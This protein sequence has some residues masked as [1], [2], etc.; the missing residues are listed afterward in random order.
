MKS[1]KHQEKIF[2]V[3]Y[4]PNQKRLSAKPLP[5]NYPL[6]VVVYRKNFPHKYPQEK[7]VSS[8]ENH[9][10]SL[11]CSATTIHRDEH[12][13]FRE[14]V[15]WKNASVDWGNEYYCETREKEELSSLFVG[16]AVWRGGIVM[17]EPIYL[18]ARGRNNLFHY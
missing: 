14:E 5:N 10:S 15:D 7:Q 13:L 4:Q 3:L 17:Q 9:H 11:S 2:T 16:R 1:P 18:N 8:E 6:E 12:R